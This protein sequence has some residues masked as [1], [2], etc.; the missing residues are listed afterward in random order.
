MADRILIAGSTGTNGRALVRMLL[1]TTDVR[2]R[3]LVRDPMMITDELIEKQGSRFEFV[4]GD[5]LDPS[6]LVAAFEGVTRAYIVTSIQPHA[7][8]LFENFFHAA[9]AADV[10]HLVKLSGL[11]SSPGS[12]SEIIRQH[13]DTDRMLRETGLPYT[14]IRPNSFHQNM[15][16][17]SAGIAA[18]DCFYLPLGDARQSTIDIS[19]IAEITASILTSDDHFGQSYDLTGPE[20]LSFHEVASILSDVSGRQIT[21]QPVSL[22][23]AESAFLA[24]GMPEWTARALAEIQDLFATGAYAE[25]L[26][27]AERLLGRRP[28]TFE[29]FAREHSA[30]WA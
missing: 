5:L 19:D 25:V 11:G 7:R 28:R 2:V 20:S 29:R 9:E 1:D 4:Q 13:G 3:A 12:A 14:I 6:S 8:K 15:L 30:A 26:P 24:N 21:Y 23:Q 17:Q 10:S 22:A 27:D 16:A 18:N